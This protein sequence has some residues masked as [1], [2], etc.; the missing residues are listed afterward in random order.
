GDDIGHRRVVRVDRLDEREPA[1]MGPLYLDRIAGVVLV[2]GKGGYEDRAVDADLVH[3]RHHLV[4]GDVFGPVWHAMPGAFRRVRLVYMD[5]GI[6]D[7]HRHAPLCP[8]S[9]A[10]TAGSSPE[11]SSF[12]CCRSPPRYA[13]GRRDA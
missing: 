1:G 4:T 2:H 7:R 5:L 9:L 13:G 8:T 11:G 3:R 12:V 10:I 6:D